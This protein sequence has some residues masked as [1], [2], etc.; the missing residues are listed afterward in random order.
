MLDYRH[1]QQAFSQPTSQNDRVQDVDNI[2]QGQ[3]MDPNASGSRVANHEYFYHLPG[4]PRI[5][6]PPPTLTVD[7]PELELN[8]YGQP[9]R[10][11]LHQ[12]NL[13]HVL[14]QNTLL[15]WAYELRHRAQMVLPF[16]YL[17]P[18]GAAKDEAFIRRENITMAL[19]IRTR[20]SSMNSV[21]RAAQQM[22]LQ[23]SAINAATPSELPGKFPLATH[24]ID[25]HLNMIHNHSMA[26]GVLRQG[27]VLVF[28]ESGNDKSAA[29]VAAYLM[30]LLSN[31]DHIKAMQ[32]CQAQR[33][34]VNFDDT[35]K[36]LLKSYMDIL[37][38]QRSVSSD[39]S[40]SSNGDIKGA[41]HTKQTNGLKVTP[42]SSPPTPQSGKKRNM[43]EADLDG[44]GADNKREQ[45]IPFVDK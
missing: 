19:A 39:S 45:R 12:V 34:C 44:D 4:P 3:A 8:P 18:M 21:L 1:G 13:D 31:C 41:D 17:G 27:K 33:F 23:V 20:P 14:Q 43:D 7:L 6:V 28:C 29:I 42:N 10:K 5:V 26:T 38:A 35:L 30:T 36:Q 24:L 15:E 32:I 40:E 37:L 25:E 16:L 9:Q 2:A 11:F 22:G